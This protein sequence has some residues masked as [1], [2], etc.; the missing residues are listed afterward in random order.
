MNNPI[1]A[2]KNTA[3]N[4]LSREKRLR[5][6]SDFQQVYRS[7]QWGGSEY[8]TFN[9]LAHE[10]N[11]NLISRLGVTVSKK[12]AKQAVQRNRIKR[13]IKEFYRHHCESILSADLVITAKP[14]CAKADDAQRLQ[15]LEQ[16][17]QK[18]LKWQRWHMANQ[19]DKP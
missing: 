9:V 17:W 8:Y 18:I 13:Q 15:S 2:K 10:L 4:N 14:K 6:P 3:G 11:Q 1:S 19:A 7:K 5:N 12:V 16:L